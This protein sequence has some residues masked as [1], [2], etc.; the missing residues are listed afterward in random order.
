MLSTNNSVL[1]GL[2][3]FQ[4]TKVQHCA[5]VYIC[6]RRTHAKYSSA[7]QLQGSHFAKLYYIVTDVLLKQGDGYDDAFI[8][9]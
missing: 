6:D 1:T 9:Q 3:L 5:I 4:K 7:E 2:Y 8:V